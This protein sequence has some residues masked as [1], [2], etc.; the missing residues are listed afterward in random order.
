VRTSHIFRPLPWQR[1]LIACALL[2]APTAAIPAM[3]QSNVQG[4]ASVLLLEPMSLINTAPLDFGSIIPSP[5]G[6]DVTLD[7]SGSLTTSGGLV[8]LPATA[9][10]ARFAGQGSA[11][12]VI[13]RATSN[14]IF[15][16][17]PGAQMRVDNFAIGDL[18][19]LSQIGNGNNYRITSAN[20]IVGFS[21]G[22]RLRV[23]A[24]QAG[25]DYTGSFTITFNYQ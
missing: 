3:A 7:P 10:P 2:I 1:G 4:K 14:Q 23:N 12:R 13:I 25:G 9:H 11:S 18:S 8:V 5:A 6:G 21:V 16:T 22:G 24:N 17:G 20:G 19:G 15:L